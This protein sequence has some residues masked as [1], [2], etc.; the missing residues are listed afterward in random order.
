MNSPPR[1][2]HVFPTFAT[3]GTQLRIVS[4]INAQGAAMAHSV[5][6]IDGNYQASARL[7]PSTGVQC[8]PAPLRKG[9]PQFPFQLAKTILRE[10]PDLVLT[11][12]WGAMD[13]L[14]GVRF[15]SSVPIVHN[16][17]GFGADE[18]AGFKFRRV[19]FRRI[20]LRG[21]FRTAVTS[22]ALLQV[23]RQQ[24]R[25]PAAKVLFIQTGVNTDRFRP[26]RSEKLRAHLLG[27]ED[28]LLFGYLGGLRAEKN[29]PLML[30]AFAAAS[31][32]GAR[33]VLMGDG[34]RRA[35]LEALSA[36]LGL[37]DRVIFAG[38]VKDP[39]VWLGSLDAFLM[40]SATEQ[41]PNALL[42]AMACGIPAFCTDAGDTAEL[43][44][45]AGDVSVVP[46]NDVDA[47][48]SGLRR[49]ASDADLRG[50][51]GEM[52]RAR[53]VERYSFHKMVDEYTGLYRSA[54]ES[55]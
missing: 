6:A 36:E 7:D 1:L 47:Y 13:A 44:A 35:S 42:E 34:S 21:V 27:V 8:L 52:N 46:N 28:N 40:S 49:L 2:V 14:L 31:L 54:I 39:E 18:A 4:I 55:R 9:G 23:A 43:L 29:L 3:G 26:G 15:T 22:R 38:N 50:R 16:E 41:M 11:Y 45:H 51:L 19:L 37:S 30:R 25:L 53:C 24:Y 33:L 48:A 17:C 20:F 10:A 32:S 12:N 5:L